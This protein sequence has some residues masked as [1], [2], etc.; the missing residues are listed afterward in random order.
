MNVNEYLGPLRTT[1]QASFSATQLMHECSKRQENHEAH[2][3]YWDAES[4]KLS[5]AAEGFELKGSKSNEDV[6]RTRNRAMNAES[7][8][9]SHLQRASE[10]RRWIILLEKKKGGTVPLNYDD[11]TFFFAPLKELPSG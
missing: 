9:D 3:E 10:C 1:W 6:V 2:A 11:V 4:K 7:T 8:R 5:D